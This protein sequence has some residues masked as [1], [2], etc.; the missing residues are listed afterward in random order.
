MG[1]CFYM[2]G[3]LL[4][5]ADSSKMLKQSV[6]ITVGNVLLTLETSDSP[7]I[8]GHNRSKLPSLSENW[9]TGHKLFLI[10]ALLTM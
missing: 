4:S 7:V 2:L 6:R 10:L 9:A 5:T 3:H 1:F 8:F